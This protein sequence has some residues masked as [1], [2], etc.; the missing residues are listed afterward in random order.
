MKLLPKKNELATLIKNHNTSITFL[1]PQKSLKSSPVWEYFSIV[2]VN[3]VKQDMVCCDKCKHLL[4]YRQK[5]GTASLAKHKRSCQVDE[6]ASSTDLS[7]Q[8]KVTEYYSSLKS[9][10]ISKKIKEKVKIACICNR[11][12]KRKL[13][14][15]MYVL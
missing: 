13:K 1:K 8:T 12:R 4:V 10:E 7:N 2:L 5:D 3:N 14:M 6:A 15:N 11:R 9:Y